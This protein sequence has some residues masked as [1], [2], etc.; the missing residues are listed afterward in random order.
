MHAKTVASSI[1]NFDH[2]VNLLSG[3]ALTATMTAEQQAERRR[4]FDA[5]N[6]KDIIG[7]TGNPYDSPA[8][9]RLTNSV[10]SQAEILW[11]IESTPDLNTLLT[12]ANDI[13]AGQGK[14]RDVPAAR[15]IY[16]YIRSQA[17]ERGDMNLCAY[18]TLILGQEFALPISQQDIPR[19]Q[20]LF[21]EIIDMYRAND[22]LNKDLEQWSKA[23]LAYCYEQRGAVDKAEAVYAEIIAD[24]KNKAIAE[25]NDR[26]NRIINQASVVDPSP[27]KLIAF[28]Q[29]LDI[30]ADKYRKIS[31]HPFVFTLEGQAASF[32]RRAAILSAH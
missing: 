24:S 14:M 32:R 11:I 2:L 5:F 23:R 21:M 28:A 17:R 13:A 1:N 10:L 31:D 9:R 30:L 6:N 8:Y 7:A 26:W 22:A 29:E 12:L 16:E 20:A 15:Y 27:Q 4:H 3:P 25:I 19:A 18:A